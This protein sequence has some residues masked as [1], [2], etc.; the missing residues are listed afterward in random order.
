MHACKNLI[1]ILEYNAPQKKGTSNL[2]D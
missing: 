2:Y 1:M